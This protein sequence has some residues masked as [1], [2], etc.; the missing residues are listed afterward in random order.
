MWKRC[1]VMHLCPNMRFGLPSC[2]RKVS[3]FDICQVGIWTFGEFGDKLLT[4]CA[5]AVSAWTA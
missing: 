2:H 5:E 4:A 3:T 1:L